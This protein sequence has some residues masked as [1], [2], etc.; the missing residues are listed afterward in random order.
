MGGG[1]ERRRKKDKGRVCVICIVK[2]EECPARAENKDE[3]EVNQRS[4]F[5]KFFCFIISIPGSLGRT[6]WN[7]RWSSQLGQS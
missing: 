2:V 1:V 7:Q 6:D 3:K 5:N 4:S